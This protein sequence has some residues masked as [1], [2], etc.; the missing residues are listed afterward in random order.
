MQW[1]PNKD[2]GE[3]GDAREAY[4]AGDGSVA[5]DRR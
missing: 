4:F 1:S 2:N 5:D 3:K